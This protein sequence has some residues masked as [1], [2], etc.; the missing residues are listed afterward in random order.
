MSVAKIVTT[1]LLLLF[2]ARAVVDRSSWR[3]SGQRRSVHPRR[4]LLPSSEI[5]DF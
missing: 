3:S 4:P 1:G 5:G 2:A